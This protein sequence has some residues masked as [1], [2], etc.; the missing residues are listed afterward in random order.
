MS[1]L[2]LKWWYS[3]D[4]LIPTASAMDRVEVLAKPCV[5][6]SSAAASRIS[7]RAV[8]P[9]LEGCWLRGR[10]GPAEVTASFLHPGWNAFAVGSW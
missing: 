9:G 5:V 8:A 10:P 2:V 4:C 6:K 3:E 7:S 1:S